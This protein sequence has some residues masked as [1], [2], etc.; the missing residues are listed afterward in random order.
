MLELE[1]FFK[2][3]ES[4][5]RRRH[6]VYLKKQKCNLAAAEQ[7]PVSEGEKLD[8]EFPKDEKLKCVKR[9]NKGIDTALKVLQSEYKSFSKR[10]EAE[11]AGGE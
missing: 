2:T 6:I 10:M 5:I 9:F 7:S 8:D 1:L 3:V 11:K 4:E